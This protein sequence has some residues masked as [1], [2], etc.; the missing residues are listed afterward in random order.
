MK[1]TSKLAYSNNGSF[2][3]TFLLGVGITNAYSKDILKYLV[4]FLKNGDKKLFLVTPNAEMLVLANGDTQFKFILNRA[5]LALADSVGITLGAKIMGVSLKDR[6][7]GSTFVE[8]LC[9]AV[10]KQPITVG[11][12]GGRGN[13]AE[14]A[15]ERL[16]QKYPELKVVFSKS[17]SENDKAKLPTPA[18]ILF[19][20]LGVPK[21]EMFIAKY[22][23]NLPVKAAVGVGGAF[24]YISG[25]VVRAPKLIQKL[26]FEWLFRLIRQPWRLKRQLKLIE[27]IYLILKDKFNS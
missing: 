13:V 6:V 1:Q 2:S 11:F 26:G 20:A 3:K 19:V 17:F 21:Q 16:K 22:L 15:A 10:A 24:D 12:L 7:S 4:N 8:T 14:R 25:D 5:D 18:D 23:Q 9:E 27:F